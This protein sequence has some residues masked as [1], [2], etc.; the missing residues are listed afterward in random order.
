MMDHMILS[1][2]SASEKRKFIKS[3]PQNAVVNV[4]KCIVSCAMRPHNAPA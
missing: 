4:R 2:L 1:I 3:P